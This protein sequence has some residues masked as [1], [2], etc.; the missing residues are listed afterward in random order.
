MRWVLSRSLTN[1]F[2]MLPVQTIY[3]TTMQFI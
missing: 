3:K 1:P 2:Q